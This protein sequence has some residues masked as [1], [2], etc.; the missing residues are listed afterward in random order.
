MPRVSVIMP[1]Y[2]GEKT[3]EESIESILSQTYTDWE[4]IICDDCSTD[5]T[6]GIAAEYAQKYKNIILLRNNKNSGAGATRNLCIRHA[7]GEFIALMDCD[8]I[9]LPERLEN[10]VRFLEQ[11]TEYSMVGSFADLFD[12][13]GIY[14]TMRYPKI[15]LRKNMFLGAQFVCASVVLR[16][17]VLANV[18]FYS[19]D[20]RYD[21]G[22]D[23]EL[24]ARIYGAGH[25]GYNIQETLYLY[26]Y[27]R[28][29]MG[30]LTFN[31]RLLW[32]GRSLRCIRL[33]KLPAWHY[34]R[35]IKII[36]GAFIPA[37][38]KLK[39][40]VKLSNS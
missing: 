25:I 16:N 19:E 8:D 32:V 14:M 29:R 10:Q 22:E 40:R 2:N 7:K 23:Q 35:I 15:P 28:V 39:I 31:D 11:N 20:R 33:L 9:S 34:L 30:R 38:I 1:A 12:A 6:Y 17:T 37:K 3:I 18:G 27:D 36:V 26:R 13:N 24:Y 21:V 5:G 4:L